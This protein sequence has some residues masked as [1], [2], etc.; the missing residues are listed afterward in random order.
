MPLRV[1]LHS[2]LVD[3][4]RIRWAERFV[5]VDVDHLEDRVKVVP[6]RWWWAL[7]AASWVAVT[8]WCLAGVWVGAVHAEPRMTSVVWTFAWWRVAALW[9][10][11]C[12]G[13][14]CPSLLLQQ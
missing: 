9:P 8:A 4:G 11:V 12:C 3:F 5:D 7:R 2:A 1:R 14:A 6:G 13:P 10:G